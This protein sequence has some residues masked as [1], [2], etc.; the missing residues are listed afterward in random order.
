MPISAKSYK[1]IM[2]GDSIKFGSSSKIFVFEGGPDREEVIN[3]NPVEKL[4]KQSKSST[5]ASSASTLTSEPSK[6]TNASYDSGYVI[7][8]A[9]RK[10]G[11]AAGHKKDDE[12]EDAES[13]LEAQLKSK[14]RSRVGNSDDEDEDGN[15]SDEERGNAD[16]EMVVGFMGREAIEGADDDNSFYDRTLEKRDS[17]PKSVSKGPVTYETIGTKL[18]VLAFVLAA[19]KERISVLDQIISTDVKRRGGSNDEEDEVDALDAFMSGMSRTVEEEEER[20]KKLDILKELEEEAKQLR[21]LE[22]KL[23]P[24]DGEI[25]LAIVSAAQLDSIGDSYYNELTERVQKSGGSI[26]LQKKSL[27]PEPKRPKLSEPQ[28]DVSH[29]SMRPPEPR[30]ITATRS[31]QNEAHHPPPKSESVSELKSPTSLPSPSI[32]AHPSAPVKEIEAPKISFDDGDGKD[33]GYSVWQAPAGQTGDG[34]TS[35]NDK[36]GY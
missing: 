14:K 21:I 2:A 22:E 26:K 33:S 34:R 17:A 20:N 35:L 23:K 32:A 8:Q 3:N 15:L 36:Y 31:E 27:V 10:L 16:L 13:R 4:A 18:R 7:P 1:R 24:A 5:S 6:R 11:T 28:H 25:R 12:D 29:S 19:V 30:Y 9:K